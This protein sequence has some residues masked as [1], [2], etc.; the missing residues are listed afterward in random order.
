MSI[1]YIS[2]VR[3]KKTSS[4]YFIR[5]WRYTHV[6]HENVHRGFQAD[7]HP[8][9]HGRCSGDRL[10]V[11]G[12]GDWISPGHDHPG[13]W[14]LCLVPVDRPSVQKTRGEDTPRE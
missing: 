8:H 12:L 5:V 10:P 6:Q 2:E 14:L 1:Y 9:V 3:R 11:H 13:T 4:G 7:P